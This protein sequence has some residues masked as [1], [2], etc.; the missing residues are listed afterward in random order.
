MI[1]YEMLYGKRPFHGNVSQSSIASGSLLLGATDLHFDAKPAVSQE[2][3]D[4]LR[5]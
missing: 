5:R 3:K 2:A 1:F 4:F